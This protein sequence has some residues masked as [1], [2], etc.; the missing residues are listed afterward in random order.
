MD[1]TFIWYRRLSCLPF[2]EGKVQL[3]LKHQLG[4]D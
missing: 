1:T 4:L 3:L 2:L